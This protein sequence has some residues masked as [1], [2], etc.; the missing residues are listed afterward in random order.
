[1][2]ALTR[3]RSYA[4]PLNLHQI[5]AVSDIW[6]DSNFQ[7]AVGRPLWAIDAMLSAAQMI[8]M[9]MNADG[10]NK[11]EKEDEQE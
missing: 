10:T 4:N 9:D 8:K 1:M 11:S 2:K 3:W 7:S 5:P 6:Y